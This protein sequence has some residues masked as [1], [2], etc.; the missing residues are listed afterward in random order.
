M[1]A[2][3]PV[4]QLQP[5]AFIADDKGWKTRLAKTFT[6]GFLFSLSSYTYASACQAPTEAITGEQSYSSISPSSYWNW[7]TEKLSVGLVYTIEKKRKDRGVPESDWSDNKKKPFV[8]IEYELVEDISGNF[9]PDEKSWVPEILEAVAEIELQIKSSSRGFAFWDRR[10]LNGPVVYGYDGGS[11]CGPD[12]TDT[13]LPGQYYLHF[14]KDGRTIGLEI[15]AGHDDPF[16]ADWRTIYSDASET[17]I[18]RSPKNYFVELDGYQEIELNICPTAAEFDSIRYN[19]H[20]K[21]ETS[22]E[23]LGTSKFIK[24]KSSYNSSADDVRL[25]DFLAYQ[26]RVNGREW[27]CVP[28]TS[29]MVLDKASL[30]SIRIEHNY[31]TTPPR[32]RFIEI[33]DGQVDTQAILSRITILPK[34]DNN[35]LVSV[36]Q[37]KTWIR[38]ANK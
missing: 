18:K 21:S 31:E 25:V 38:E 16:V 29:Y 10:D 36:N 23:D 9:V 34:A 4:N 6:I 37:A 7:E 12:P 17:K 15:V 32:H 1:V 20:S 35:T 3:D 24:F 11:M 8:K 26:E 30:P 28:N 14:R 27:V 13:V 33:Q 2:I 19:Q 5:S 22:L